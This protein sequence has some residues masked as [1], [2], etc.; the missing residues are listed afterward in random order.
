[1]LLN[2]AVSTPRY[3]LRATTVLTARCIFGNRSRD[4]ALRGRS[5]G[6]RNRTGRSWVR[7]QTRETIFFLNLKV[8]YSR[9]KSGRGVKL[10]P[11]RYLAPRL[12]VSGLIQDA[13]ERTPRFGRVIASGGERVQWWA[14]R[15]RTAVFV[16][17]SMYT[18]VWLGEHRAFLLRS[19]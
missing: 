7:I 12:R 9:G 1:L 11:H 3:H 2:L 19:L 17:F 14:A 6:T 10:T 16:P 15:R 18:M 4:P 5:H 8:S 13:A